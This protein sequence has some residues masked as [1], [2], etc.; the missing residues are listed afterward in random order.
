MKISKVILLL[1]MGVMLAAC[2]RRGDPRMYPEDASNING[3]LCY[4]PNPFSPETDTILCLNNVYIGFEGYNYEYCSY[5]RNLLSQNGGKFTAC[6]HNQR[7]RSE[8]YWEY[9]AE[10]KRCFYPICKGEF[11]SLIDSKTGL[12]ADS[13]ILNERTIYPKRKRN[14]DNDR[15]I[16]FYMG[17]FVHFQGS[18]DMKPKFIT[19]S[20]TSVGDTIVCFDGHRGPFEGDSSLTNSNPNLFTE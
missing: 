16:R 19:D 14:R 4:M 12:I 15:V 11:V 17:E 5:V 6:P 13:I 8:H 20:I 10:S 2:E 7:D 1:L 9:L 3:Q 18:D